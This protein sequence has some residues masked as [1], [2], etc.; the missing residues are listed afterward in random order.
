MSTSGQ[1]RPSAQLY[2]P[3]SAW[4]RTAKAFTLLS[5]LAIIFVGVTTGCLYLLVALRAPDQ[6]GNAPLNTGVAGFSMFALSL[7]LGGA[8]LFQSVSAL[9]RRPSTEFRVPHPAVFFL[10]F[11]VVVGLG[12]LVPWRGSLSWILFPFLYV[13]GI[14]LPVGWVAAVA[15]RRLSRGEVVLSWRETILQLSS[16]AFITTAIAALVETLALMGMIAAVLLGLLVT[17]GGLESLKALLENLQQPGWLESP[18]NLQGLLFSPLVLVSLFFLM[19]IVVPLIEE[20]LK[21][22]GVL[23]MSYRRPSPAR[24][25]W[26]GLLGGAGFAFAEGLFNSNL[27]IGDMS[28]AIL[29]PMRFGTTILHCLTGAL[30]GLGWH[31]LLFKKRPLLWLSRYIQ[32]VVLHTLWNALNL[33]LMFTSINLSDGRNRGLTAST[34]GLGLAIALLFQAILMALLLLNLIRRTTA[35][36]L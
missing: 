23:L 25:L 28:W 35:D 8:L 1:L 12:A 17:P 7:A 22:V 24:A 32:A 6:A 19:S 16:G 36:T 27:A 11:I 5:S 15:S 18:E 9:S 4:L 10:A 31:A 33:A 26:W 30:M 14:G 34:P 20:M 13:L 3:E 2:T 29:A 21:T